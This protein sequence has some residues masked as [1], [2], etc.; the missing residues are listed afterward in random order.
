MGQQDS[1]DIGAN[2]LT[3]GMDI[4]SI[5]ELP[6]PQHTRND[7]CSDPIGFLDLP[8]ELRNE[9]Y[10][11]LFLYD[12]P[13][14]TFR[15]WFTTK[16][17][18]IRRL[19]KENAPD[20][21]GKNWGCSH[22]DARLRPLTGI[23]RTCPQVSEEAL[24]VL[25]TRNTFLV[26]LESTSRFLNFFTIGESNLRR[27]RH[28][29]ISAHTDFYAYS[30]ARP[31]DVQWQFF[32]PAA[33][34]APQWRAL[35]DGLKT[36]QFVMKVPIWGH[37]RAWPVWVGQLE[38][39]IGFV[40]EHVGEETDVT[41]DDNYSMYLC[42]AVDRCFKKPFRRVRTQDGDRYYYKTRFD[43]ENITGPVAS[44]EG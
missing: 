4:L 3:H 10:E 5:Q 38:R 29:Q 21:C 41:I 15:I 39:V 6:S 1:E 31:G 18:H 32:R 23:L 8:L 28:L 20:C 7:S 25:Y 16:M 33:D 14:F 13:I 12:A 27:I 9:V 44:N 43:P 36:L 37:H 34:E 35:L 26:T 2:T 19:T 42:E 24:E 11:Y 40:G 30:I 22:Y 17:R